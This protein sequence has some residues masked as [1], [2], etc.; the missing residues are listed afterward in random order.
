MSVAFNES[1]TMLAAGDSAGD[2]WIWDTS[3]E[4]PIGSPVS[5]HPERRDEGAPLPVHQPGLAQFGVRTIAFSP[6]DRLVATGGLTVARVY[7]LA[8]GEMVDE[9]FLTRRSVGLGRESAP[10][11]SV[12][13]DGAGDRL[14]LA[15]SFNVVGY[16][17]G[18]G[19][20]LDLAS[21]VDFLH[22]NMTAA[23]PVLDSQVAIGQGLVVSGYIGGE[24]SVI[25]LD[26]D[27]DPMR[28]SAQLSGFP[29][30]AISNDGRVAIG[31]VEGF[32]LWD[33]GSGPLI[34]R[35][36]PTP[37]E[38]SEVTLDAAG[39]MAVLSRPE[40]NKLTLVDLQGAPTEIALPDSVTDSF[41][42]L[43]VTDGLITFD[44]GSGV[45]R[46]RPVSALDSGVVLPDVPLFAMAGNGQSG[47]VAF[48]GAEGDGKGRVD[49]IEAHTGALVVTLT[50]L[51]P[52]VLPDDFTI[53]SLS[54]NP[55]GSRL[56]GATQDGRSL[57][58]DTETWRVAG[59]LSSGGGQVVLAEYSP[60]GRYLVTIGASGAIVLRDPGTLQPI[61]SEIIGNI[62][63]LVGYSHGPG[64]TSDG[65]YMVTTADGTGRLWDLETRTQ[66][67]VAF[68]NRRGV[69]AGVSANGQTLG[70]Y[71]GRNFVAWDLDV[72]GW[73][74]IACRAVGRNMTLSEWK[75]FGPT[76]EP[77]SPTCPH[78]PGA[79][80]TEGADNG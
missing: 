44:L 30:V 19:G 13:F 20:E 2:L 63:G 80:T 31:G 61:G 77:Y 43:G 64:F 1:G 62:D 24:V 26:R 59:E 66:I 41:G 67:G 70:T 52:E 40:G 27:R 60:E 78:W 33:P 32:V 55:D 68:P 7:D 69:V 36:F 42:W 12:A 9:V 25:S 6:D 48:A 76:D 74:D 23:I 73:F 3:S 53:V 28:F 72:G 75:Q 11:Q 21:E 50:D 56:V 16:D 57:V 71:D 17:L 14:L 34:A 54:F 51:S 65:R 22:R 29:A 39:T 10:V 18:S 35:V 5:L 4:E 15:S 58:W 46:I 45:T 37:I 38:F 47:L 8:A 79:S 49:V